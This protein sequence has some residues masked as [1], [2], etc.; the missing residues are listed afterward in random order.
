MSTGLASQTA[1]YYENTVAIRFVALTDHDRL[2]NSKALPNRDTTGVITIGRNAISKCLS[3]GIR[4]GNLQLPR[5]LQPRLDAIELPCYRNWIQSA[6][7]RKQLKLMQKL[8]LMTDE[9]GTPRLPAAYPTEPHRQVLPKLPTSIVSRGKIDVKPQVE[10][11]H[12]HPCSVCC[13]KSHV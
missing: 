8:R 2:C 6:F 10:A 5:I 11:S 4:D 12:F 1:L 9:S 13:E 3:A 7:S